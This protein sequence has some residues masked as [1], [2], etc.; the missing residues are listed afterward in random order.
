MRTC[1]G[2]ER[3]QP[4][5]TPAERAP[6]RLQQLTPVRLNLLYSICSTTG[7]F[8]MMVRWRRRPSST[9]VAFAMQAY[10]H[11]IPGMDGAAADEMVSGAVLALHTARL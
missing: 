10:M 5:H 3:V 4:D 2:R 8:A 6:S 1:T 9:P 7:G 11:V